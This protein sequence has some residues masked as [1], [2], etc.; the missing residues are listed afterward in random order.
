VQPFPDEVVAEIT[1][2]MNANQAPALLL[3]ARANGAPDDAA[4]AVL[5]DVGG[6]G[7][8][9]RVTTADGGQQQ[10]FVAWPAP[11]SERVEIREELFAML[12]RAM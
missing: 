3:I 10:L 12:L 8:H 4:A 6:E 2:Y 5:T 9:L 7:A 1:A 11:I